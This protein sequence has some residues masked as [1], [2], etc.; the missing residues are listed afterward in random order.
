MPADFKK[1]RE[2]HDTCNMVFNLLK[3]KHKQ[4]KTDLAYSLRMTCLLYTSDAAD[5]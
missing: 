4:T 3:Q 1:I 2:N 5:E